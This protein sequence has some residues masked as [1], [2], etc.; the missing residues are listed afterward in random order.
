MNPSEKCIA[1]RLLFALLLLCAGWAQAQSAGQV[2]NVSGPLFAIKG[3]GARRVLAVGSSV[4]QGD[5]LITEEKTYARI[6]FTDQGEITLRPGTQ[7]KVESYAFAQTEPTKDNV[8]FGLFKG[9][10]RSLT[11]LIGKRGNQEAYR[12]QTATATI[13]IRGTQFI[14]ELVPGEND[15][16]LYGPERQLAMQWHRSPPLAWS[17]TNDSL[18]D[19]PSG[20]LP[21]PGSDLPSVPLQLAANT[22]SP[23]NRASG[24]YVQVI[25]GVIYITNGAGTQNIAA[26]EFGFTS[27]FLQPPVLIPTNPGMEFNPPPA[28]SSTIGPQDYSA[29]TSTAADC[30]VR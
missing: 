8:V 12:L 13:G 11:G 21:E 14:A 9:A 1:T 30:E 18:S 23:G 5:M 3:D 20:I 25:E 2:V 19:V 29:S 6:K 17:P 28:F 7:L 27:G 15:V 16:A 4:D 26:G 10:L 22:P 24:L